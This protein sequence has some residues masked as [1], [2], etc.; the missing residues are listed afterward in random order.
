MRPEVLNKVLKDCL[1]RC[2][3]TSVGVPA[4]TVAPPAPY[5]P[6]LARYCELTYDKPGE[7]LIGK[8]KERWWVRQGPTWKP[9]GG[10]CWAVV[11]RVQTG[12][13]AK[14]NPVLWL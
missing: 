9:A 7:E 14:G 11:E 1:Q 10:N 13:D 6:T 3:T 4:V 5:D 12:I 2:D 8:D